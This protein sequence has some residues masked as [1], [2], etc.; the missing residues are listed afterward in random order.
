MQLV[1]IAVYTPI[2]AMTQ[3]GE[4]ARSSASKPEQMAEVFG[5]CWYFCDY[6]RGVRKMGNIGLIGYLLL[7]D[8]HPSN[9]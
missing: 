7:G 1:S 5:Y 3:L 4:C 2:H 6:C 8:L 9:I